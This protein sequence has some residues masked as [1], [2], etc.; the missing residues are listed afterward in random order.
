MGR[1][2]NIKNQRFHRLVAIE[3]TTEKAVRGGFLWKCVCDC[4][5]EIFSTVASLRSNNTKSCGCL[6]KDKTIQRN[7]DKRKYQFNL[8]FFEHM[9]PNLAYILGFFASDG[10]MIKSVNRIRFTLSQ[11]DKEILEKIAKIIDYSSPVKISSAKL[12]GKEY[13]T[14][15]LQLDSEEL[16]SIF[17]SYGFT[18]NKSLTVE[19]PSKIPDEQMIHFIRGFFD[20]DGTVGGQLPMNKYGIKTK[21]QQLRVRIGCG[22][23]KIIIQ[24]RDWL[25]HNLDTK[26]VNINT[27]IRKNHWYEIAYSTHDSIK[28][29]KAFYSTDS[30]YLNRKKEKLDQLIGLRNVGVIE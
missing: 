27:D 7:K 10:T 17:E 23:E 5:N 2:A 6:N 15:I 29:Y 13:A 1:I 22:S 24:I 25:Y 8:G 20:G 11:N 30:I 18:S 12:N 16:F 19:I 21:S 28:L 14:C 3:S 4:G 26:Y 9:S